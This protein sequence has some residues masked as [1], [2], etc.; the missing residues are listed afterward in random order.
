MALLAAWCPAAGELPA[1][2]EYEV[3]AAFL[4]NFT[5]FI[6]WPPESHGAA[7]G[8]F[9]I[10]V[11]GRDSFVTN[12]RNVVRDRK[13]NGRS[14]EVRVLDDVAD[15]ATVQIVFVSGSA[16]A[17]VGAACRQYGVLAV[18]ESKEFLEQG[19]A[20]AF[21]FQEAK[22]R[23]A[24]NIKAARHAGLKVSAQL[25]KLAMNVRNPR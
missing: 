16:E 25:Q 1:A 24:I 14:V 19:G 22:L 23:F 12:L 20:I 15:V 11:I 10:G 3:K 9:V 6:E 5:K 7:P 13:V 21:V 17:E 4:Y 18:G 8:P 2:K